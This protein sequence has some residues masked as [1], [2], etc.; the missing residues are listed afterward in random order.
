MRALDSLYKDRMS[1]YPGHSFS[2]FTSYINRFTPE[3]KKDELKK[4][5]YSGFYP[6]KKNFCKK[7]TEPIGK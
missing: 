5:F 4:Y 2:F 1:A 3:M 7:R 6:L